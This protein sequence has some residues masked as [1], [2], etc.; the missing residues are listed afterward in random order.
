MALTIEDL[1]TK[2]QNQK[3]ARTTAETKK[4]NAQNTVNTQKQVIQQCDINIK[5][6]KDLLWFT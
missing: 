5:Y 1:Q 4:N 6:L 2:L 3:A